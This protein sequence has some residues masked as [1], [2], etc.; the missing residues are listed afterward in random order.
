MNLI[1]EI[2]NNLN[3]VLLKGFSI[4]ESNQT[5]VTYRNLST[6]NLEYSQPLK[7]KCNY[8]QE[9]ITNLEY[10]LTNM[11][12]GV[13][14]KTTTDYKLSVT[15]DIQNSYNKVS[16]ENIDISLLPSYEY[17]ILAT[18]CKDIKQRDNLI[19]V[20]NSLFPE[21]RM[22]SYMTPIG[23]IVVN[24]V[25]E[26]DYITKNSYVNLAVNIIKPKEIYLQVS[27]ND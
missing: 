9:F 19:I 7:L 27:N 1:K 20:N 26:K 21:R 17:A 4:I 10:M 18:K 8:I 11:L 2:T 13:S 25:T 14:F 12:L 5:L 22:A 24:S 6:Y 3:P 16:T 23:E 15:G